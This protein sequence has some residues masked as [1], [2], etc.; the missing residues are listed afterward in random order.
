MHLTESLCMNRTQLQSV[1][2]FEFLLFYPIQMKFLLASETAQRHFA[3]IAKRD[4]SEM[5]MLI[6]AAQKVREGARDIVNLLLLIKEVPA[7]A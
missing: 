2:S 7:F 3:D 5:G 1:K 4:E 6:Q